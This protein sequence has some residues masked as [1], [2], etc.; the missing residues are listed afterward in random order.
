MMKLLWT[1]AKELFQEHTVWNHKQEMIWFEQVWGLL[2]KKGLTIWNSTVEKMAVYNRIYGTVWIFR[3]FCLA[4][5]EEDASFDFY[6]T[7]PFKSVLY[8]ME[9]ECAEA[10]IVFEKLLCD[11]R[12]IYTI[13]DILKEHLGTSQL[14]ASLWAACCSN[15]IENEEDSPH[16]DFSLIVNENLELGKL[17]AYEWLSG[18]LE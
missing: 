13:F 15:E 10:E 12:V 18:Y 4:G 8:E 16:K 5:F 6:A 1:D 9:N 14:F 7:E 3:N 2:D 11:Q 17:A